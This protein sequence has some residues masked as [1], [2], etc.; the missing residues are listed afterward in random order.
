MKR[1]RKGDEE[2][3]KGS[4]K[5]MVRSKRR[6]GWGGGGGGGV[7]LTERATPGDFISTGAT[8]ISHGSYRKRFTFYPSLFSPPSNAF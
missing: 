7:G 2:G 1:E 8:D 4:I 5:V 3:E 6:G